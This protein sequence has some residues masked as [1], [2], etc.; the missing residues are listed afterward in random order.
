MA[1]VRYGDMVQSPTTQRV[2]T[3]GT[4]SSAAGLGDGW[5]Q[6][7][8]MGTTGMPTGAREYAVLVSGRIGDRLYAGTGLQ[9]G[10]AEVMLG[11]TG[12]Q[13]HP[14]HVMHVP[15]QEPIAGDSGIAFQFLLIVSAAYADQVLGSSIDLSAVD[16]CLYA[17]T[18][19]DG[20][21][22]T[23]YTEF[24]VAD[25]TWLWFDLSAIDPTYRRVFAWEGSSTIPA[26]TL[27]TWQQALPLPI[28]TPPFETHRW[29]AIATAS[30]RTQHWNQPAPHWF[31]GYA[32]AGGFS[33]D[34]VALGNGDRFGLNRAGNPPGFPNPIQVQH[35]GVWVHDAPGG[36]TGLAA[37]FGATALQPG[38]PVVIS[39]ALAVRFLFVRLDGLFDVL[40]KRTAAGA[41]GTLF[42]NP[43][44]PAIHETLERPA[45]GLLTQPIVIVAGTPV[46]V[47]QRAAYSARLWETDATT[48]SITAVLKTESDSTR[49]ERV[50]DVVFGRRI[51]QVLSPAMQ[52]RYAW[53]G[54]SVAPAATQQVVD[55]TFVQ[56][57]P[58]LNAENVTTPPGTEPPPLILVPTRQSPDA[59]DLPLPP[60]PPNSDP[61]EMPRM[62]RSRIQ[63]AT[64]YARTWPMGARSLRGFRIAWG[65][66]SSASALAVFEFLRSNMAWQYVPPRGVA[67]AVLNASA[68]SMQQSSHGIHAVSIDVAVL[69]WT[70]S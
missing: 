20:D 18:F 46:F 4:Q 27:S 23:Y 59:D 41:I 63:G 49:F 10:R 26:G 28:S 44:W 1:E 14:L 29:L 39:T 50:Q 8:S 42:S 22:Q 12:G 31:F 66:M 35:G 47:N 19:T 17:R 51:F 60:Y 7:A 56:F 62:E 57:H 70:G 61:L 24:T 54:N 3:I 55:A 58:V 15:L 68:P 40:V 25:V 38:A 43:S 65:P 30:Y 64:G 11:L 16:L 52:W 67:L 5:S 37:R 6:L 2:T 32:T 45:A 48:Q 53:H 69:R 9:R 33:A 36:P 34:V 21:P 13:R